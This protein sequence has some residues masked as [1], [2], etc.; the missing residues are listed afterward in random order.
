MRS[1]IVFNEPVAP[2]VD[3]LAASAAAAQA[4]RKAAS[5]ARV[6][7]E[8]RAFGSPSWMPMADTMSLAA[9]WTYGRQDVALSCAAGS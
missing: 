9:L 8:A 1:D 7:T 5:A 2:A 3:P 6:G 4:V